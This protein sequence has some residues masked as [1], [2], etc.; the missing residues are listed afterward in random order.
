G[1]RFR[2]WRD[3]GRSH[4]RCRPRAA[5]PLDHAAPRW[6]APRKSGSPPRAA[7]PCVSL[8]DLSWRRVGTLFEERDAPAEVHV[9]KI[10]PRGAGGMRLEA[11]IYFW[12]I[13]AAEAFFTRALQADLP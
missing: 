5:Y 10:A 3:R 4:S 7:V 13:E 8:L 1:R 9:A 11:A 6:P 12:R 2:R